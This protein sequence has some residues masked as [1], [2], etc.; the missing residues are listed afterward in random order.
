VGETQVALASLRGDKSQA[1]L[2]RKHDLSTGL[3]SRCGRQ[4]M[5][6]AL[7]LFATPAHPHRGGLRAGARTAGRPGL[8]LFPARTDPRLLQSTARWSAPGCTPDR[9]P[10]YVIGAQARC[11]HESDP[12]LFSHSFPHLVF[13]PFLE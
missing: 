12:Y 9:S 10:R 2:W 1:P 13:P 5:G 7:K 4:L 3:V 6:R 8:A 11:G